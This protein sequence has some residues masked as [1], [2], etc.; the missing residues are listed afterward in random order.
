MTS[1]DHAHPPTTRISTSKHRD[2]ATCLEPAQGRILDCTTWT[3]G[4]ATRGKGEVYYAQP[5]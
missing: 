4:K 1:T 5:G 3:D 2:N